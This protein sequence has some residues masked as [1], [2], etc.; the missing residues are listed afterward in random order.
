M[1]PVFLK[2][3]YGDGEIVSEHTLG[4]V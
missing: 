4:L 3:T 1:Q 2:V